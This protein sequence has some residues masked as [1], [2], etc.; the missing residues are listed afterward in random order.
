[1]ANNLIVETQ[2]FNYKK[3]NEGVD[4][5]KTL[6]VSGV[7]Q[8]KGAKNQNGRIYPDAVLEREVNKYQQ[9]IKE[10]RAMGELDHPESPVVSLKNVSHN[11]V[12]LGWHEDDLIGKIEILNTPSGNILRNLLESDIRIGI[13]SRGTGTLKK[14]NESSAMVGEDF[15]LIAFDFVSNPSVVGAFAVPLHEGKITGTPIRI[16]N[17]DNLTEVDTFKSRMMRAAGI[18]VEKKETPKTNLVSEGVATLQRRAGISVP[19]TKIIS[20]LNLKDYNADKGDELNDLQAIETKLKELYPN[21]EVTIL[22]GSVHIAFKGFDG[23]IHHLV[24]KSGKYDFTGKWQ[25]QEFEDQNQSL[26]DIVQSLDLPYNKVF[27]DVTV[28]DV[29]E[30]MNELVNEI[31]KDDDAKERVMMHLYESLVGTETND[32]IPNSNPLMPEGQHGRYAQLAGAMDEINDPEK[33]EMEKH[34]RTLAAI[35]KGAEQS[36]GGN[37]PDVVAFDPNKGLNSMEWHYHD[38]DPFK[39]KPDT[40]FSPEKNESIEESEGGYREPDTFDMG[41][42]GDPENPNRPKDPRKYFDMMTPEY[43][44]KKEKEL[45]QKNAKAYIDRVMF[46][47]KM[48]AAEEERRRKKE[49]DA[50]DP[51]IE[52]EEH[53]EIDWNTFEQQLAKGI[54]IEHE[55]TDDPSVAAEIAL[56]HLN[57]DPHYYDKLTQCGLETEA[58]SREE[59]KRDQTG[60]KKWSRLDRGEDPRGTLENNRDATSRQKNKKHGGL[61]R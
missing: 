20:E 5:N 21:A 32:S 51:I 48:K 10:R 7:V 52:N 19:N 36:F 31:R 13:S 40:G 16:V 6:L 42:E 58:I 2:I 15:D 26:D 9:L 22:N 56:D 41:D 28:A 35:R 24:V 61:T 45:L 3:L 47:A 37:T 11:I 4:G 25:G 34:L 23:F 50:F 30:V 18:V 53:S 39:K 54:E 14:V 1:M 17:N 59:A 46:N 57:E 44:A 27:N 29:E 49:M 12:E 43:R 60:R 38:K 33:E 55:H 8:R